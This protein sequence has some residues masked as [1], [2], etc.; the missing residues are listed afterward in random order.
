M[1]FFSWVVF[2]AFIFSASYYAGQQYQHFPIKHPFSTFTPSVYPIINKTFA[3]VILGKNN[4]AF[5][6]K[7]L[8]SVFSQNYSDYHVF[9]IDDA[10]DDGSFSFVSSLI[11]DSPHRD[12]VTLIHNEE[13]LGT[14]QNLQ[15]VVSICD[16]NEVIVILNGDD[17]LA[18]EWVLSTLNRYYVN[19]EIWLTFGQFRNFPNYSL[20]IDLSKIQFEKS[21]R[22]QPFFASH[23]KTFYGWLFKKISEADLVFSAAEDLAYM[24][25]MLEMAK[26]HVAMVPDTLYIAN[27]EVESKDDKDSY[28]VCEQMIRS[29]ESYTPIAERRDS[30]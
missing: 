29:M 24:F 4:G 14:I 28:F 23:L 18:H 8:N 3:I 6:E 7:T 10:S 25:P 21:L 12:R 15:K 9:Y 16:E 5:V 1:R 30:F 11:E 2:S 20:G 13:K 17:W 19:P 27:A 22:T 26:N